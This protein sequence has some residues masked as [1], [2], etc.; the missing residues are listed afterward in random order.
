MTNKITSASITIPE[1]NHSPYVTIYRGNKCTTYMKDIDY[2]RFEI[3]H[4]L[5]DNM[6]EHKSTVVIG[7][8]RCDWG[9][10]ITFDWSIR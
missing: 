7:T 5:L 10:H 2:R 3:I 9:G 4:D 6:T 8:S 1:R